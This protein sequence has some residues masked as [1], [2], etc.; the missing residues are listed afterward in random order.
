MSARCRITCWFVLGPLVLALAAGCRHNDLVEAELRSRERELRE[1][2]AALQ[3]TE[4]YNEALLRQ[5][6]AF[7]QGSC[8][9]TPELA[10]QTYTLHHVTLGYG[11]GGWDNDHL[12][13]DEALRV[14]VEPRDPDNHTVKAP[15]SLH[16]AALQ[17]SPEGLKSPLCCWDLSPDQ[18]RSTWQCNLLCSGYDVILPWKTWPTSDRLRVVVQF[19]LADGRVFETDRDISVRLLPHGMAPPQPPVFPPPPA[20]VPA[21]PLPDAG[22]VL[23]PPRPVPPPPE[24][25]PE[26]QPTA[27]WQR[28]LA[29]AEGIPVRVLKPV[30]LDG[31]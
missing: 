20:E 29:P 24:N 3:Q 13:G 14:F 23:P 21:A 27:C 2:S 30:P 31:P 25:G 7:Q 22:H 26:L 17:I 4:A 1:T 15:G 11:T 12:P 9:V 8:K 28:P 19:H 6:G 16:V 10:S 5:L 18:L